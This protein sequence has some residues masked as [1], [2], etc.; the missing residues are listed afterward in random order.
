M[1]RSGGGHLLR[2]RRVLC[3]ARDIESKAGT[4]SGRAESGPSWLSFRSECAYSTVGVCVRTRRACA[5]SLRVIGAEAARAQFI[6]INLNYDS[7]NF[8]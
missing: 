4:K 5:V 2:I 1:T 7:L 6:L 8:N 3:S